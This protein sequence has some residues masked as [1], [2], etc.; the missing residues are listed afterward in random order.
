MSVKDMCMLILMGAVD[1]AIEPNSVSVNKFSV[2]IKT[3]L[4]ILAILLTPRVPKNL[5]DTRT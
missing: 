1:I 5:R 2:L 3:Y 4:Q